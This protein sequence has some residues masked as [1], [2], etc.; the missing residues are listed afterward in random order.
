MGPS[1]NGIIPAWLVGDPGSNP[2][3]SIISLV[4]NII[5]HNK[6][7]KRYLLILN[8]KKVRKKESNMAKKR[9]QKKDSG[10]VFEIPEMDFLEQE[11]E[12]ET[13]KE[14]IKRYIG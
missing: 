2:G 13:D 6:L 1:Y 11:Q 3:G 7:F 9:K 4:K 14:A 12:E 5:Y 10:E 8:I